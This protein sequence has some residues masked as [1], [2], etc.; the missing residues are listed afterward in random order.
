MLPWVEATGGTYRVN[1]RLSHALGD[2]RLT[3]A[4]DGAGVRVIPQELRELPP[5]REFDDDAVLRSLADRCEQR[6]FG[7]GDVVVEAGDH[8]DRVFLLA[9][10]KADKLGVGEYG[11]PVVLGTLGD[12]DQFGAQVLLDARCV[13]EYTVKAATACTVLTLTRQAFA[14]Q[15]E[16]SS[17]LRAHIDRVSASPKRPRNRRGE[18]DIE[19]ASGHRGE[20]VLPGTFVDYETRP[21]E[22]ELSVAQTVLRVH[23]RVADLYNRPMNQLDQ[24]LRL[25]V[26]ALRERQEHDLINNRDFGLLHNA[27][28]T[29]RVNTRT[30]PPTPDDLDEILCRRRKSRLFLAHPRAIAAFGRECSRRGIDPGTTVVRGATVTSWRG[31]P[32][33]PCDKIPVSDTNTTSILVMRTGLDDEGV[34]GLRQTGLPDEHEPGLNVRFIGINGRAIASYLVSA[35]YCVAVL[36]P[37]ALGMLENVQIGL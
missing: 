34:I 22:Y 16:R 7:P 36:V 33:L 9:H 21:R 1:R 17:A 14:E 12:G 18:A 23:T 26:E 31:V 4:S 6:E 25:T 37:D 35:Y 8:I 24:Q 2:G 28:V 5:L 32:I 19:L 3:F 11:D 15:L 29:Q 10:G 30:G 27:D 20:P 13:W